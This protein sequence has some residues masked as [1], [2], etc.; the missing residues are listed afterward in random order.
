[1]RE[2]D[3]WLTEGRKAFSMVGTAMTKDQSGCMVDAE[4]KQGAVAGEVVREEAG[5]QTG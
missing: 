1:M 4:R 2:E 5:G 3:L